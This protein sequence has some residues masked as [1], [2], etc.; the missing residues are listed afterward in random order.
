MLFNPV[1]EKNFYCEE[2]YPKYN[3]YFAITSVLIPIFML[4]VNGFSDSFLEDYTKAENHH[5]LA[6]EQA[7]LA[8]KQSVANIV[9]TGL[10]MLFIYPGR[11]FTT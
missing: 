3:L 1:P 6:A 2:W 9:N 4:I 5:D 7:S 8:I 11:L 10:I